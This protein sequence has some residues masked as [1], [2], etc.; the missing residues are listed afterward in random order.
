MR[1]RLVRTIVV[2]GFAI[3][4]FGLL[5]AP[6]FASTGTGSGGGSSSGGGGGA[7]VTCAT[8]S[9]AAGGG[10]SSSGG[11]GGIITFCTD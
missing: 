9:F 7:A 10:G 1:R 2:V 3:P 4:S 5:V 6:A 8:G 11:S